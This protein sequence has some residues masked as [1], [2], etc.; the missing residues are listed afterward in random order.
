[1][2]GCN[3][4]I[5]G[6]DENLVTFWEP[7]LP[8]FKKIIGSKDALPKMQFFG[9]I[10]KVASLDPWRQNAKWQ[11]QRFDC[12]RTKIGPNPNILAYIKSPRQGAN[13]YTCVY[14]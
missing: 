10:K 2:L 3:N 14:V 5:G 8:D 13:T 9:A 6:F 1:V 4:G 7:K 12:H 11:N